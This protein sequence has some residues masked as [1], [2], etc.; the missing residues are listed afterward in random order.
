MGTKP[1]AH[2]DL[3]LNAEDAEK[4]VGGVQKKKGVRTAFLTGTTGS[5]NVHDRTPTPLAPFPD[6]T[7][8]DSQ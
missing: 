6:E 8:M 3:A 2:D 5:T 1:Q 4:V 7:Y